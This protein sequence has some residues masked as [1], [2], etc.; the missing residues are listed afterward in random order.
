M[1]QVEDNPSPGRARVGLLVALL[2]SSGLALP[3]YSFG[4]AAQSAA[5][6]P[7][8]FSGFTAGLLVTGG[9]DRM[10]M[11][12]DLAG[13]PTLS[14]NAAHGVVAQFMISDDQPKLAWS[15][16]GAPVAHGKEGDF[17]IAG[18]ARAGRSFEHVAFVLV[19]GSGSF[20]FQGSAMLKGAAVPDVMLGVQP[21]SATSGLT[22]AVPKPWSDF[23]QRRSKFEIYLEILEVMKRGPMT[24]FEVAFYARLNH[25]RTKEYTEYL[26]SNGYLQ[27]VSEDGKTVYVLTKYGT[28]FLE[29][30]RSLFLRTKLIEVAQYAYQRDF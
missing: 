22:A 29:G 4:S 20:G 18:A 28:G 3:L 9:P 15:P 7:L 24:P 14:Q 21:W 2:V 17:V 1:Q 25:K 5:S 19:Q 13:A 26:A 27:A 23:F 8:G 6:G 10:E 30:V 11:A 16:D 12:F